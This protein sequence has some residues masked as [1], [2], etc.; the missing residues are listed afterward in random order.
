MRALVTETQPSHHRCRLQPGQKPPQRSLLAHGPAGQGQGLR[1][2]VSASAAVA[3]I[4]RF[5]AVLSQCLISLNVCLHFDD[6]LRKL[7]CQINKMN[8]LR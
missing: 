3:L 1:R 6:D 7:K 4:P 5:A 2:G 8:T